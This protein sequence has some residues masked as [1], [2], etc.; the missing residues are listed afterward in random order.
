MNKQDLLTADK[1]RT[2]LDYDPITGVFTW[3]PGHRGKATGGRSAGYVDKRGYANIMIFR[4]FYRAHRLAWLHVYGEWPP[5][6]LDHRD[7]VKHHN[8]ISNLRLATVTQNHA[9]RVRTSKNTSGYKGVTTR[10]NGWFEA[11]ITVKQKQISLGRFRCA[12]R[13]HAAYR[14]A[15]VETFGEFAR[16]E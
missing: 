11:C 3:K 9:N 6:F 16:F 1:L 15:A 13:A 4:Y 5:G 7:G 8:W 10:E 2:L 14:A 12:R